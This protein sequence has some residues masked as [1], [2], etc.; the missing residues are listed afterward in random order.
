VSQC[1]VSSQHTLVQHVSAVARLLRERFN[2]LIM[3]SCICRAR[4]VAYRQ[5]GYLTPFSVRK[6]PYKQKIFSM[7]THIIKEYT[8]CR[9][10]VSAACAMAF[11][12]QQ[13]AFAWASDGI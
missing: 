3:M 4:Y 13:Q 12:W 1:M 9:E 2:V 11:A 8:G 10:T 7:G 5:A 6:T